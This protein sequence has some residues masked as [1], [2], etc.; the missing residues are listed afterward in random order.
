MRVNNMINNSR[1]NQDSASEMYKN[2]LKSYILDGCSLPQIPE[3]ELAKYIAVFS[4]YLRHSN[5]AYKY[6]LPY[7]SH[8]YKGYASFLLSASKKAERLRNIISHIKKS[9]AIRKIIENN[10]V[11]I[12]EEEIIVSLNDFLSATLSRNID[13]H[14]SF[15][16]SGANRRKENDII[17][18]EYKQQVRTVKLSSS[19]KSD[20]KRI[21]STVEKI[22]NNSLEGGGE[23]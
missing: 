5:E 15:S 19:N 3:D 20:L 8:Q 17:T 21:I 14:K 2:L 4:L 16:L 1:N 10:S 6:N 23:K 18:I 11:V 22:L 7:L 9:V 12:D 13:F